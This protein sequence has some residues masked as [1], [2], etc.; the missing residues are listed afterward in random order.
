MK[1]RLQGDVVSKGTTTYAPEK[2]Q[3]GAI[4]DLGLK[5]FA[6]SHIASR[7]LVALKHKFNRN[8]R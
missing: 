4:S 5:F 7:V 8:I 3:V 6:D 1:K 2:F